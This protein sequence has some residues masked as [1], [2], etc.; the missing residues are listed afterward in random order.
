MDR[1]RGALT[2]EGPEIVGRQERIEALFA[3]ALQKP[4][5]ERDAWLRQ[6]CGSDADL[7]RE[8]GSLLSH[9]RDEEPESW[10]AAAAAE[11]IAT[12]GGINPGTHIGTYEILE[13]IGAGGMGEV[14][15]A[16]DSR[17]QREVAIKV[18]PDEFSR[19]PDRL[20][21]FT[22]EARVLASLNHPNIAAIYDVNERALVMELVEGPTLADRIRQGALPVDEALPI[23]RQIAEG[24][25]A[26]HEKGK[27]H[28][29]LKPANVK[30]TRD[31]LA[32]VLDFGLAKT[33]EE[34]SAASERGNSPTMATSPTRAG[35]ILGTAAYMAPEQARGQTVDKRADIWAFGCVL[36][37][38]LTGKPVFQGETTSDI[39]AAV[40]K[41]E[42]DLQAIP[43][44]LRPVIA[45]CLR[46]DPRMRWRDIGDVRLALEDGQPATVRPAHHLSPLPWAIVVVLAFGLVMA[47]LMLR[48]LTKPV[49]YSLMQLSLELAPAIDPLRGANVILSPDGTRVV[50]PTIGDDGKR[51]LATRLLSQSQSSPLPGTEDVSVEPFFSPDGEWVGFFTKAGKLKK[52][53]VQGGAAVVICDVR[54]PRG[55]SWGD[56]G[57]IVFAPDTRGSLFRVSSNG[58]IPQPL[59]ELKTGEL[60]HRWPQV[61]PGA[62]FVLFTANN[63]TNWENSSLEI[64]SLKTGQR[65]TL[66]QGGTYGRY[67]PTGHLVYVHQ[68][69]L[70]AMAFNLD[71]EEST[72]L[73]TLIFDNVTDSVIT[74]GAQFDFSAAPAGHGTL[75][76]FS[77][78]R[79]QTGLFSLNSEG[80]LQPLRAAPGSYV[81]PRFSPDGKRLAV[82]L[83]SGNTGLWVL[84]LDRD[85]FV[86]LTSVPGDNYP[87]W[88]PDGKHIAYESG[89][90]GIFWVRSDGSKAPERLMSRERRMFPYSFSPDGRRLAYSELNPETGADI[91][92]LPLDAGDSDH[93]TAGTPEPFLSTAANERFP[94]LSPDGQWLAYASD[95]SGDFEVY[96]RPFPGPGGKWRISTAGGLL[97]VWSKS[98][99]ELAYET[100][101]GRVMMVSYAVRG[102]TFISGQ[103]RLWSNQQIVTGQ[104][105]LAPDGKRFVVLVAQ[106]ARGEQRSPGGVNL[107]LNFFDYLKQRA[108]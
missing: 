2:G 88:S 10:A 90:G 33:M 91:W 98:G 32:K 37:E 35:L 68:S 40:I 60:T 54:D 79:T 13:R 46:K 94:A 83:F 18:L 49:Q 1:P 89:Q 27:V 39:L 104:G 92:T 66:H 36:F 43:A 7:I 106:P 75:I 85:N 12:S 65:K 80:S 69:T 76:Y 31:G 28:R 50:F 105:D 51:R 44:H 82:A 5:A 103:P 55:A 101:D 20:V 9:H 6:A 77:G 107:L 29:D 56:D 14:Y 4:M 102:D 52:I 48:R 15:R 47:G 97:P 64:Q 78:N 74:G 67:L 38:M 108:P 53:P 17:L 57:N 58:G 30:I 99:R 59:T 72:G 41:E 61:L 8:V 84:D 62:R 81:S 95:E 11:L 16:R 96:V 100:R 22:R 19:D 63:G 45:K 3:G 70:F 86:R 21:R 42:P 24:L 34:P 26:A 73:P 87:I 93:P 25:E 71:R 23:A